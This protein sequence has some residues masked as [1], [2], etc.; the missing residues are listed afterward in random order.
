LGLRSKRSIKHPIHKNSDK[1][2][3][4]T[5][6]I[7]CLC[8]LIFALSVHSFGRPERIVRVRAKAIASVEGN[9]ISCTQLMSKMI[10][11][12]DEPHLLDNMVQLQSCFFT[13]FDAALAIKSKRVPSTLEKINEKNKADLQEMKEKYKADR[14]INGEECFAIWAV[15]KI[16][17]EVVLISRIPQTLELNLQDYPDLIDESDFNL[18]SIDGH[19]EEALMA[20]VYRIFAELDHEILPAC[21]QSVTLTSSNLSCSV[22]H[23]PNILVF[24]FE[25]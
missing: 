22:G 13:F 20:A 17:K 6:E 8:F 18:F 4:S 24:K 16:L 5:L 1:K 23:L 15:T 11:V 9:P 2:M 3:M 14:V 21:L 12:G 25:I 7:Q 10:K 19:F